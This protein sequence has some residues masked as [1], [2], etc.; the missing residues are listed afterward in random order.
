M[1]EIGFDTMV[2]R[3]GKTYVAHC[4][5]LDVSSCGATVEQAR[6]MLHTAVRLFLEVL[7]PAITLK[8]VPTSLYRRL[9]LRAAEHHRSL[10][11]EAIL[12]L[13]HSLDDPGID[14]VAFLA[15]ADRVR[16]RLNLYVTEEDLRQ[17]KDHGRP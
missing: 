5:E 15:H 3:E 2:F 7:M 17:A 6:R 8:S 9:K 11:R 16:E 1:R 10:N 4:P 14:P 13:E 12:C